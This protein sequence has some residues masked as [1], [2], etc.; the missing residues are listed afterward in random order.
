[1]I[2]D[3]RSDHKTTKLILLDSFLQER[4]SKPLI[5]QNKPIIPGFEEYLSDLL[6]CDKNGK[7]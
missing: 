4:W 6:T 5:F 7:G 3:T 2:T 1:M